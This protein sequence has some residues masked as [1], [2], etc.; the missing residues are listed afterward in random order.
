MLSDKCLSGDK[1][2]TGTNPEIRASGASLDLENYFCK[3]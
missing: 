2:L 1:L 3:Y